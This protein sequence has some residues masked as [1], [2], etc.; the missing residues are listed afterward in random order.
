MQISQ[1]LFLLKSGFSNCWAEIATFLSVAAFMVQQNYGFQ[2]CESSSFLTFQTKHSQDRCGPDTLCS[3][4]WQALNSLAAAPVCS[5]I[6][7]EHIDCSCLMHQDSSC[8]PLSLAFIYDSFLLPIIP[9]TQP[10]PTPRLLHGTWG[11]A[12]VSWHLICSM[13]DRRYLLH[14][15]MNPDSLTD[16]AGRK[17]RIQCV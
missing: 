5:I 17:S 2:W 13:M 7:R 16:G 8:S 3:L 12:E 14:L 4:D 10:P 9:G 11:G 15:S 1:P 6:T